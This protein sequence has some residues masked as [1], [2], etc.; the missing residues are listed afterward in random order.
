MSRSSLVFTLKTGSL[1]PHRSKCRINLLSEDFDDFM[2]QITRVPE[3]G[4]CSN[5][6]LDVDPAK[7]KPDDWRIDL[8][9]NNS[10]LG[11][12]FGHISKHIDGKVEAKKHK[13]TLFE[14][15]S[16]V[17]HVRLVS[18]DL[19]AGE[20][21]CEAQSHVGDNLVRRKFEFLCKDLFIKFYRIALLTPLI[22]NHKLIISKNVENFVDQ[23]K[24]QIN[25]FGLLGSLNTRLTESP[26][27][28]K[29][30]NVTSSKFKQG[31]YVSV[32]RVALRR[33]MRRS[34][35]KTLRANCP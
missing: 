9:H 24:C 34:I 31:M 25:F 7:Y 32:G 8:E 22:Y 11:A 18:P 4:E 17:V 3:Q 10:C 14:D 27:N 23:V 20:Y 13:L 6:E 29:H 26:L 33:L 15:K 35:T 30:F 28:D 16:A 12:I 2:R 19:F 1:A 5:Q 21:D